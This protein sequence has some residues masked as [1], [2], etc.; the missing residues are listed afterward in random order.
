MKV[1]LKNGV[2]LHWPNA[3][4]VTVEGDVLTV[5]EREDGAGLITVGQVAV[6]SLEFWFW[7]GNEPSIGSVRDQE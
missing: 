4:D 1:F 7:D 2:C 5:S 6:S 3:V